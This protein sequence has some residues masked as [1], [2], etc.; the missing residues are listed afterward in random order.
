[1]T[2]PYGWPH[3]PKPETN[4]RRFTASPPF[5][6]YITTT[7]RSVVEYLREKC[8]ALSSFDDKDA[9]LQCFLASI[10]TIDTKANIPYFT[11]HL[12]AAHF[13]AE[14]VENLNLVFRQP[15]E[16]KTR[17]LLVVINQL[18]GHLGDSLW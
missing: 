7:H 11:N 8:R 3:S 14:F 9:Y 5:L 10:K 15:A 6:E 2:L 1:M 13:A 18:R 12:K 17:R 16:L 4:M